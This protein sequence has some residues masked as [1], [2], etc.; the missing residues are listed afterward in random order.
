MKMNNNNNYFL[1]IFIII[2]N[3]N[4]CSII[5][6]FFF[7]KFKEFVSLY[8]PILLQRRFETYVM[9]FEKYQQLGTSP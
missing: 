6:N 5:T 4:N 1:L 7:L 2:F 3:D 8:A 9:G